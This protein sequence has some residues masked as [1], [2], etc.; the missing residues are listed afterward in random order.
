MAG[1]IAATLNFQPSNKPLAEF[2]L[3]EHVL[4]PHL[5]LLRGEIDP[6]ALGAACQQE[7]VVRT[8]DLLRRRTNIGLKIANRG[9]GKNDENREF[10]EKLNGILRNQ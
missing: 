7:L 1:E 2:R 6:A 10:L 8:E 9:Q 5:G 4:D 3:A